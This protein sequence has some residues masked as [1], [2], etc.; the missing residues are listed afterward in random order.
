[1]TNIY[2]ACCKRGVILRSLMLQLGIFQKS[3]DV[4]V[5]FMFSLNMAE[6][7]GLDL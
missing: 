2:C 3:H 4:S 5:F 6:G 7:Q 1:M